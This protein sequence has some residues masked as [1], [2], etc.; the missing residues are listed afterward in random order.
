MRAHENLLPLRA[1][2]R[3]AEREMR[4]MEDMGG[5]SI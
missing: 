5:A 3:Q 1:F 2:R 4:D